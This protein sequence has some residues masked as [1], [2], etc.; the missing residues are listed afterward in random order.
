MRT[1]NKTI[2]CDLWFSTRYAKLSTYNFAIVFQLILR[3]HSLVKANGT[4]RV[5]PLPSLPSLPP[6]Q[7][8]HMKYEPIK[9]VLNKSCRMKRCINSKCLQLEMLKLGFALWMWIYLVC[10]CTMAS[11]VLNERE[12]S[13][14]VSVAT[15]T[16][17]N[18]CATVK[19][20]KCQTCCHIAHFRTLKPI[21]FKV[22][23]RF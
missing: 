6:L 7:S 9:I 3:M 15:V 22:L 1:Y 17:S 10:R 4:Q 20:S 5:V 21:A 18:E 8:H 14:T 12:R 13:Y 23:H 19:C 16:A 2:Q 11:C